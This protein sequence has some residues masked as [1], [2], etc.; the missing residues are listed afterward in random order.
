MR[1]D[2]ISDDVRIV[3]EEA[4]S[5]AAQT[6]SGTDTPPTSPALSQ[7]QVSICPLLLIEHEDDKNVEVGVKTARRLRL[8][9]SVNAR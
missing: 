7:G 5:S 4:V 1:P 3:D 8:L 2:L 9:S 6:N